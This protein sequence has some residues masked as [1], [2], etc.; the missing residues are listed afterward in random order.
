M[1]EGVNGVHHVAVS[2]PDL[3]AAEDFYVNLLGLE[4]VVRW[5][6]EASDVGDRVTGLKEA[7]AKTL[8]IRA[9]N[10]Y[11]E[12]FEYTSPAPRLQGMNRPV[13]DHGYTHIA[14]DVDESCI[15]QVSEAWEKAGIAW[16]HP[17]TRDTDE[18]VT[19]TYGRDPFGNVI[20]IQA[21]ADGVAFHAGRL[22]SLDK[23]T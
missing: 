10:L 22:D 13:C 6:F 19:M 23:K 20:E 3:E 11:L 15:E 21:L 8:M 14:F 1:I 2:V 5:D 9:G 16:H 17:L 4:K 12:L 7:A 18:G